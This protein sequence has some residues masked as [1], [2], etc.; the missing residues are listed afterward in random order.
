MFSQGPNES[1][2]ISISAPR[3]ID[4]RQLGWWSN[5]LGESRCHYQ[6]L[7]Q[8][9]GSRG[10]DREAIGLMAALRSLRPSSTIAFGSR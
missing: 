1:N 8:Y 9:L 10:S 4:K 6:S 3:Q 2:V 5:R 7:L